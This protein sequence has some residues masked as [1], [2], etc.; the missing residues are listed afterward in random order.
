ME[1]LLKVKQ[2]SPWSDLYVSVWG[3]MQNGPEKAEAGGRETSFKTDTQGLELHAPDIPGEMLGDQRAWWE[4]RSFIVRP[5]DSYAELYM[6]AL[7]NLGTVP[8]LFWT[9][10]STPD[11]WCIHHCLLQSEIL[12]F[13]NPDLRHPLSTTGLGNKYVYIYIFPTVQVSLNIFIQDLYSH[14]ILRAVSL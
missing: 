2:Q 1:G 6:I 3:T 4:L 8:R 11:S 7:H 10:G 12:S 9:S 5:L 14:E 13:C